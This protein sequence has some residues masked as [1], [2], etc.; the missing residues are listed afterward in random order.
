M[1]L[2]SVALDSLVAFTSV[3][4]ATAEGTVAEEEEEEE[5]AVGVVGSWGRGFAEERTGV[6]AAAA[7]VAVSPFLPPLSIISVH[8]E[9]TGSHF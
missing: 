6:V 5:V 8:V 4:P 1:I 9:M 2:V 7:A 3:V